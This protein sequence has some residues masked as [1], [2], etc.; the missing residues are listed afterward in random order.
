MRENKPNGKLK[1]KNS[2]EK[3][4]SFSSVVPTLCDPMVFSTPGFPVQHQRPELTQNL[5]WIYIF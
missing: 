1:K 4:F 3:N 5:F 2:G